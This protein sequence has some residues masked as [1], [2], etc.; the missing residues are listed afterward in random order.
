MILKGEMDM[1]F[2]KRHLRGVHLDHAKA[3]R[4][5]QT[6]DALTPP[7][8]TIPLKQH[9]GAE[10]APTVKVGDRVFVGQKIGDSPAFVSA[11]IHA[12]VS[13]TVDAIT[14][15]LTP[16]NEKVKCVRIVSDGLNTVHPDLMPPEISDLSGFISAVRDAGIVG[17]GGAGFPTHVKLAYKDIDKVKKLYINLAECE[18]YI[19]ADNRE[20]IEN[21]NDIIEGILL[22]LKYTGIPECVIVVENNKPVGI[23]CLREAAKKYDNIRVGV[24]GSKYPKGAEKVLVFEA[25]GPVIGRGKLPADCGAIVMNVTSVAAIARYVRTGIPL[26]SRRVTVDG[27]LVNNPANLRVPIGTPAKYI[28]DS[29]GV[30]FKR[31]KMLISG[32][33]MMGQCIIDSNT[34]VT[35]TT[36]ALLCFEKIVTPD[37]SPCIRCGKCLSVCPMGLFPSDIEKA[38]DARNA[39]ALKKLSVDVCMNCGCCS[40]S[41]PAKR[42]LSH[43]NQLA[44]GFLKAASSSR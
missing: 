7:S 22:V 4:L 28:L 18:P 35:K 33:A 19:T 29:L 31:L 43:K 32:G 14:E 25:G 41:C 34:P 37:K 42:D 24:V 17:L 36:N 2:F 8:V 21:T 23:K 3:S 39:S 16:Q 27:D 38:Y 40:Y 44:K 15:I 13:G 10:C 20:A 26:V 1:P 5:T 12:S 30:D 6:T 11:P 9:I